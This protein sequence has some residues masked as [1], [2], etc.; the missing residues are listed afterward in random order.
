[1]L[2]PPGMAAETCDLDAQAS[3]RGC[4]R[5]RRSP[6]EAPPPPFVAPRGVPVVTLFAYRGHGQQRATIIWSG[7]GAPTRLEML[8]L[9]WGG[10]GVPRHRVL[11]IAFQVAAI[12]VVTFRADQDLQDSICGRR[13]M[14]RRM[15]ES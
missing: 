2:R 10:G 1:M 9:H 13:G 8:L 4:H 3:Q 6:T 15:A 14:A 5:G 12:Y 11:L 7:G